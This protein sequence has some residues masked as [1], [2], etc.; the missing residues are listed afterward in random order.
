MDKSYAR[1]CEIVV[2]RPREGSDDGERDELGKLSAGLVD[3]RHMTSRQ[4]R[5]A[6]ASE[7]LDLDR[8]V[9]RSGISSEMVEGIG[10]RR[11]RGRQVKED[12]DG[13]HIHLCRGMQPQE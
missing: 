6:L 1:G 3:C 2:R 9:R 8:F 4:H 5:L 12:A 13:A 11:R 10:N 7:E